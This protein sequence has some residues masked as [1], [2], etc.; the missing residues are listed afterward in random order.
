M[1]VLS[2]NHVLSLILPVTLCVFLGCLTVGIPLPVLPLYIHET[3]HFNTFI[4]GIVLGTQSLAALLS[5]IWVGPLVDKRG[6]NFAIHRGLVL[7]SSA[8]GLYA[9][10]FSISAFPKWSLF[11][12]LIG[13]II[14]GCG[15][16]LFVTGALS[17]GIGRVGLP[18]SGKVLSWVGVAM[19]GALGIGAPAGAFLSH[20]GGFQSVAAA[21]VVLPIIALFITRALLPMATVAGTKLPFYKVIGLIWQYGTGLALATV[22]VSTITMFVTLFFEAR[23]WP[24]SALTV[25]AFGLAFIGPRLFLGGVPDKLGGA[26]V[27]LVCFVVEALGQLIL[28][29]ANTPL[30]A[31]SGAAL[32]GLGFSLIFP[33]LGIEA[34]RRVPVHN[35]GAALSAFAAF[36]DIAFMIAGPISGYMAATFGYNALYLLG[37]CLVLSGFFLL[38]SSR[39][40][41]LTVT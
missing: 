6:S 30:M 25:T 28:G 22:G 4:V 2:L 10:A 17:W 12:L 23:N 20:Y 26:R 37:A 41:S 24:N 27:A 18:N 11:I 34:I 8:G 9:L 40:K 1:T 15:E 31:F 16:S 33:S 29:L 19:Y 32:T 36:F 35:R 7:A 3:L 38:L 14:L 21:I 39:F 5:R 13:R